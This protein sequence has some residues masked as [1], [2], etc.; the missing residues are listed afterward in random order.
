MKSPRRAF[1]ATLTAIPLA[2]HVATLASEPQAAPAPVPGAGLSDGLLAAAR[3]RYR[4]APDEV[5]DVRKGIELLLGAADQ[6]HKI[7]LLNSDE[8]VLSFE[9]RPPGASGRRP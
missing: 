3:A 9:A 6:L 2:P 5:E 1:L 4:L 7:P 8:P